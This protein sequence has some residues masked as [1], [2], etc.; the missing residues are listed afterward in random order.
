MRRLLGLLVTLPTVA[1]AAP[2]TVVGEVVD[3]QSRWTADGSRIVTEATVRTPD[4]DV[5]VSQLG[6]SAGGYGMRVFHGPELL[7]V[8]M[9]VSVDAH[10][11]L[12][13]SQR[14]HVVVDHVRITSLPQGFVQTGPTKA[15][16]YLF[17]ESGCVFVTPDD[18]GTNEVVGGNEFVAISAA[19]DEW[20]SNVA[21]CSYMNIVEQ[22]RV[23]SEV[24]RDNR[25]MIK[26]RDST[27]CR[28]AI[29]DDPARCYSPSAAGI[30]TAIFVD[31]AESERDGAIVDA[32]IELNGADFAIAEDGQSSGTQ[33]CKSE[34]RNT[35]T[36]ELGHLL[37]LEHPCLAGGDPQRTDGDGRP[38]PS[39]SSVS[40]V[41]QCQAGEQTCAGVT[42]GTGQ[43][44]IDSC[45]PL[46]PDGPGCGACSVV[47]VSSITEATMFNFQDCGERKK[48]SLSPDDID[49]ICTVYPIAEDPNECGA[50]GGGSDT[51]CSAT[52]PHPV[53]CLVGLGVVALLLRPRRRKNSRPQ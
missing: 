31:D 10:P 44:C 49:A 14:R 3:T 35:L 50:V 41:E 25:N 20:N 47:C 19:I 26:F 17:W 52:P 23:P 32:D 16:K 34:I 21:S 1:H 13:L 30:T 15:G 24:G 22:P 39:C 40:G 2:M 8:G 45:D 37:G 53:S 12:D 7:R 46:D 29:G 43:F 51:C 5:V 6:G 33:S 9:S 27:W 4:G 38:V 11:D 48:Q 36:H 42:C 18:A 28:P